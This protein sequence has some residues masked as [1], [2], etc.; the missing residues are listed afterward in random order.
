M[1]FN[2][3]L[4][5]LLNQK[6]FNTKRGCGLLL[7]N[8][9]QD[10][11]EV[12]KA[13]Q[14]KFDKAVLRVAEKNGIEDAQKAIEN[15]RL[16]TRFYLHRSTVGETNNKFW[17]WEKG[18]W[19]FFETAAWARNRDFKSNHDRLQKSYYD[20]LYETT[21]P[22]CIYIISENQKPGYNGYLVCGNIRVSGST[23]DLKEVLKLQPD[24][25]IKQQIIAEIARREKALE[26]GL[27]HLA[28]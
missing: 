1:G 13:E 10:V 28:N 7:D 3:S 25:T 21:R 18:E 26:K 12:L 11:N 14:I 6:R 19:H 9:G 8:F 27:T 22:V 23:E 20:M 16:L 4:T 15:Y 24:K 17:N 5:N 2:E